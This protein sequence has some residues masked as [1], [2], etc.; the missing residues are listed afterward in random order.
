MKKY[1]FALF[2]CM[3]LFLVGCGDD[4]GETP[5]A[6]TPFLGGTNGIL[7]NFGIANTR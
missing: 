6:G 2:V 4:E 1:I 5:A 7:V 3:L